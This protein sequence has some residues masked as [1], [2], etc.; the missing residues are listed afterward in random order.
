[1][2]TLILT[3]DDDCID[4]ITDRTAPADARNGA[5]AA[6]GEVD[7]PDIDEE[8]RSGPLT[9]SELQAA[10]AGW[11]DDAVDIAGTQTR[12]DWARGEPCPECT[13]R[14]MSVMAVRED[15]Y[16]SGDGTF[17]YI[18]PG[19]AIGPI[20]SIVCADCLTRLAHTPYQRLAL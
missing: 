4:T 18:N 13:N 3:I 20:V 16:E 7:S 6:D 12:A 5:P 19:E 11:V 10:L 14:T 2:V 17:Q 1:M 15:K 9:I 8:G